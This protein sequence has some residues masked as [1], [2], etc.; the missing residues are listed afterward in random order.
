MEFERRRI[1]LPV[2]SAA[3]LTLTPMPNRPA[4][5]KTIPQI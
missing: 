2:Y 1:M 4:T 3:P 5:H